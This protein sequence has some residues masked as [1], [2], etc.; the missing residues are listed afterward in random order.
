VRWTHPKWLAARSADLVRVRDIED[1][2]WSDWQDP[3]GREFPGMMLRGEY[4]LSPAAEW[5]HAES[6][7]VPCHALERE[8]VAEPYDSAAAAKV[9]A[10]T[11]A[12]LKSA[13]KARRRPLPATIDA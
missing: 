1:W 2:P 4:R 8:G 6:V 5:Q 7:V 11:I 9:R 10:A 12:A 13:A 3:D